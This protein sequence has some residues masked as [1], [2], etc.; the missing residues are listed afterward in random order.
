[1]FDILSILGSAG[2]GSVVGGI[3]GWLGKR[4]ERAS[5]KMKYDHDVEMIRAQT[6]AAIETAKLGIETAKV[7]GSLAVEKLEAAAFKASQVT[8]SDWAEGVKSLIRPA[9]LGVLLWQTYGVLTSLEEITGGLENMPKED[10]LG[11]YR[12]VVLSVTGLT[13]TAVGWYFAA[14][15]SKQFDKLLDR[16][17]PK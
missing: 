2:F 16:W 9:I 8:K 10:V 3:F 1:M 17:H 11:L 4:E 14:R 13:A 7:A 5:M 12:I 6:D 15:S